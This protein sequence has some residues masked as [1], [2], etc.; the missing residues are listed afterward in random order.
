[1]PYTIS[2]A[3]TLV[4]EFLA[5]Y[6]LSDDWITTTRK[7]LLNTPLALTP[8]C[9]VL[10]AITGIILGCYGYKLKKTFAFIFVFTLL[11]G[12]NAD[13]RLNA[14]SHIQWPIF[15]ISMACASLAYSQPSRVIQCVGI[16]MIYANLKNILLATFME[17]VSIFVKVAMILLVC[18]VVSVYEAISQLFYCVMTSFWG[19]KLLTNVADYCFGG[20]TL[21]EYFPLMFILSAVFTFAQFL[22]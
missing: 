1:M 15:Y 8:I 5:N 3:F 16:L 21:Y 19:I 13:V 2:D 18:S 14:F 11:Y 7:E 17:C 12:T 6:E 4:D 10:Q 22:K 9:L 20:M